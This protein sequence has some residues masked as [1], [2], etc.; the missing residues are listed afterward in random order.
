MSAKGSHIHD[1]IRP[2]TQEPFEEGTINSDFT[3]NEINTGSSKLNKMFKTF[4]WPV[5][6]TVSLSQKH[7]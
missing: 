4:S 7:T 5:D 2:S 1:P 6:I 3:G